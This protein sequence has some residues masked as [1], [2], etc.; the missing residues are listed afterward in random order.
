MENEIKE[1]AVVKEFAS[2]DFVPVALSV[3]LGFALVYRL[4]NNVP[5]IDG[6]GI[7]VCIGIL[8]NAVDIGLKSLKKDIPAYKAVLIKC[9]IV[10]KGLFSAG[11]S[12]E[13]LREYGRI[14]L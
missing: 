7:S 5:C 2:D 4:V 13:I 1:E 8:D 10:I 6:L 3:A 9:C 14:N 11:S 12:L